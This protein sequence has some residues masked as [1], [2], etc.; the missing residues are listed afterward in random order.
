VHDAGTAFYGTLLLRLT[1]PTWPQL[2]EIVPLQKACLLFKLTKSRQNKLN[3]LSNENWQNVRALSGYRD[4]KLH[5]T[6]EILQRNICSR[7]KKV[8]RLFVKSLSGNPVKL[9]S[10]VVNF[11]EVRL[12]RYGTIPTQMRMERMRMRV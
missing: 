4:V 9:A 7:E 5:C 1:G 10:L 6:D 8:L 2:L 11:H 3:L 12:M